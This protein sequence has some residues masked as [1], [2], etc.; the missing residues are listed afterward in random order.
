MSDRPTLYS[1]RRCPYAMR[2]R[3]AIASSQVEC[4]LREIILR[5]KPDHM[6]EI[7]PKGTVP[8]LELPDGTVIDESLDIALWALSEHDPELLL[9]PIEGNLD[10]ILALILTM[11]QQFKP[12]LDRYKYR[13]HSEPESAFTARDDAAGFLGHLNERLQDRAYLFGSRISLADICI[14]PFVR[15][16]AFVDKDWFFSQDFSDVIIWLNVFLD[17]ERFAQIMPKFS[18]WKPG[19]NPILF[20]GNSHPN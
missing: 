2:A 3:L 6:L 1:F 5:D 9:A 19:D 11:D 14:V 4:V 10:E 8:V 7:S 20:P 17:S 13:F 16:F 18:I 12:L 15:Q